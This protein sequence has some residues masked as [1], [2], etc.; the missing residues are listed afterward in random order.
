MTTKIFFYS[1]LL[2]LGIA[3]CKS[4][5]N[6]APDVSK[7][8]IDLKTVRLDEIMFDKDTN[9][10]KQAYKKM[11]LDNPTLA[12]DFANNVLTVGEK[13]SSLLYGAIAEISLS[14]KWLR[15]TTKIM[16]KNLTDVEAALKKAYQYQKHYFKNIPIRKYFYTYILDP[17][18]NNRSNYLGITLGTNS[19]GVGL[20]FYMGANHPLYSNTTFVSD[21]APGYISRKY[22]SQYIVADIVEKTIET[23]LYKPIKG[24]EALIEQII[25]KGK[26]WYIKKLL[27]PN[28]PDTIITGFTKYQLTGSINQEGLIW[29][30]ILDSDVNTN[31]PEMIRNWLGPS[32]Y[33]N[34]TGNSESPG[35]LGKWIGLRIIEK[36][37]AKNSN[38]TLNE[39]LATDPREIADKC[40]YKPR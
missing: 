22:S 2:M 20:Q 33:T 28:A 4:S 39:L 19:V 34:A 17:V 27:L 11:A 15:D 30:N 16:Y 6:N 24:K 23:E 5:T 1:A 21:I 9:A 40:G 36:Y 8:A 14:D 18:F 10:A 38:K 25:E 35:Q 31:D 3:A 7:I 12:T 13:D 26:Q 32:P 37:V 29:K